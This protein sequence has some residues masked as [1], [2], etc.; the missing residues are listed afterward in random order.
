VGDRILIFMQKKKHV[1]TSVQMLAFYVLP[2][3]S[4]A[5]QISTRTLK[6]LSPGTFAYFGKK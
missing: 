5:L 6:K 4:Y 1:L 2:F 3:N